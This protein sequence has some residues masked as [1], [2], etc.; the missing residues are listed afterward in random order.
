[1]ASFFAYGSLIFDPVVRAV[2]GRTFEG[3][4][5]TLEG[6]ARYQ[7]SGATYPGLIPAA[8]QSVAG[9]IYMEVTDSALRRL[10]QFEGRYYERTT[11]TVRIGN[12]AEEPAETYIFR[13]AYRHVLSL[14]AW[15]AKTFQRD[16][17]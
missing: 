17:L 15:D 11:V 13:E 9:T 10:D 2:T 12:G 7:V 16:C 8:G 4:P 5:A 1:M 3:H 6:Y 14:E